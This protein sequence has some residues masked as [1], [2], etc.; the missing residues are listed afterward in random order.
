MSRPQIGISACLTGEPVRYDGGARLREKI[1]AYFAERVEW[2]PVCPEVEAGMGVPRETIE[3]AAAPDGLRLLGTQSRKDRTAAMQAWAAKRLQ[4]LEGVSGF[5][6]KARSPSCG[7]RGVPVRNR[8]APSNGMFAAA[9]VAR[10][11]SLP[12]AEDEDLDSP[13]AL[14]AFERQVSEYARRR[15][16]SRLR[17]GAD[18]TG[19]RIRTADL[20]V[21]SPSL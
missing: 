12:V 2:L 11:A 8:A 21:M 18:G 7:L 6:L 4:E 3:L 9:L 19:G 10:F 17:P 5:I 16:R 15:E 20:R 13:E 1:L 14:D